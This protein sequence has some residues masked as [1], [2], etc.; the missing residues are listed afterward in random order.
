MV[1]TCLPHTVPVAFCIRTVISAARHARTHALRTHVTC[2]CLVTLFGWLRFFAFVRFFAVLSWF[3]APPVHTR[4]R[5]VYRLDAVTYATPLPLQFAC[6]LITVGSHHLRFWFVHLPRLR[7]VVTRLI[8]FRVLP[9]LHLPVAT[10]VPLLH[11]PPVPLPHTL[12][13][14]SRSHLPAFGS[15]AHVYVYVH[16][17]LPLRLLRSS[18]TVAARYVHGC[19]WLLPRSQF[20]RF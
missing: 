12:R 7:L 8:T 4:L 18:Y 19:S 9:V 16:A 10:H 3:T 11:T 15:T 20:Y 14:R 13:L 1:T 2:L 6:V 5:S 17:V